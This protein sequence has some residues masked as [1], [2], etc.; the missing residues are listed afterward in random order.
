MKASDIKHMGSNKTLKS[1][2]ELDGSLLRPDIIVLQDDGL[3]IKKRNWHLFTI[4][5]TFLCFS[6]IKSFK[7]HRGLI[8]AKITIQKKKFGNFSLRGFSVSDAKYVK[9]YMK[10]KTQ[11]PRITH[12][13]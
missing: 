9:D 8:K 7:I 2:I 6:D 11:L 5:K 10:S 3:L 13:A 12:S 4:K 1:R